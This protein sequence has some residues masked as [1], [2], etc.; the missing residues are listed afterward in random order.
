[1]ATASSTTW[2]LIACR[3]LMGAAAAF[4][5]PSTLSILVNV[6]PPH[7]RPKAISSWAASAGSTIFIVPVISGWL[8]EHFWYG[9]VLMVNIPFFHNPA[10][11]VG[12]GGMILVFLAM[13]GSMFLLLQYL[14]LVLGYTPFSAALRVIPF[15]LMG[16]TVP[17]AT[18]WLSRRFG[19]HRTVA[20]GLLT[21]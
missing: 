17:L 1:L 8:L 2:Q 10:F 5:M 19:A 13:F 12:T 21:V 18:P 4:V 3:A 9:S 14:Q 16:I 7:E 11:S 20:T 6:F 15:G